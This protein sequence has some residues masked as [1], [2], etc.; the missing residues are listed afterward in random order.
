MSELFMPIKNLKNYCIALPPKQ[1]NSVVVCG[2][3]E[4]CEVTQPVSQF[5]PL[6]QQC[7]ATNFK[8]YGQQQLAFILMLLG[9]E[10]PH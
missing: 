6:T 5:Q 4:S 2:I 7:C 3:K 10:A 1:V 9:L 8:L